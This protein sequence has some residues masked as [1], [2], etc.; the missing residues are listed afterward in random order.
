MFISN[1]VFIEIHSKW[2]LK[3]RDHPPLT[4]GTNEI[5]A[6]LSDPGFQNP[7]FFRPGEHPGS[8]RVFAG[9]ICFLQSRLNHYKGLCFSQ[10]AQMRVLHSSNCDEKFWPILWISL[11]GSPNRKRSWRV[12]WNFSGKDENLQNA[13]N[14]LRTIAKIIHFSI[15]NLSKPARIHLSPSS[16][17]ACCNFSSSENECKIR[18]RAFWW[19]CDF[20]YVHQGTGIFFPVNVPIFLPQMG[21]RK[22]CQD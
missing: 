13:Y 22:C 19:K 14:F 16:F 11:W 10:K 12:S 9:I 2:V 1:I 20:R 4:W 3:A 15:S 18:K 7:S 8:G 21:I 17:E 5:W 6:R